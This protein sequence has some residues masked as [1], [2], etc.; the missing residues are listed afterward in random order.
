MAIGGERRES[1]FVEQPKYVGLFEGRVIAI[2][3]DY[4]KYVELINGPA[5]E[6]SK[7]F[8]YLGESKDGNT[9]LRLDF[10]LE[11]VKTRKRSDGSVVNEKFKLTFFLENKVRINKDATRTQY[12]N[13]IGVCSWASDKD[14]LPDW[15]V[16][17]P[18]REAYAGEEQLYN[19]LRMWLC[20]LDYRTDT[21]ELELDWKKLMK[22]NIRELT[23]QIGGEW[24]GNV[25]P[26]ATVEV[27]E[28]DGEV[29]EYQKIY[30]DAFLS[31]YNLKF[32]RMIDYNDPEQL[33][34][35][36]RKKST[37]LKTHEKFV[38]NIKHE[39]YGCKDFYILSDMKPYEP[40]MNFAASNRVISDEGSDY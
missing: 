9:Y 21:A 37:D 18:Y 5:K 19:F 34:K 26:V 28:K 4:E 25:V 1:N 12:I 15:F 3:P 24:C 2:N 6:D 11:E 29:R 27:S 14:D 36:K 32:F 40:D 10:W 39:E 33:A 38:L 30:N 20:N 16:K 13:N 22:G 17:R 35:L 23:S 8:E 7:Q 31:P